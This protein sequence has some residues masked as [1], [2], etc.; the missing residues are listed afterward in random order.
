[1]RSRWDA[2]LAV[3]GFVV[4]LP[5]SALAQ[6]IT[7]PRLVHYEPA[8][9]PRDGGTI[10]GQVVLK[11]QID[12]NGK[13]S[14][15][16]VSRTLDPTLDAA[17][18]AAAERLQ[19]EPAQRGD[20]RVASTISFAYDFAAVAASAPRPAVVTAPESAS[21]SLPPAHVVTEPAAVSAPPTEVVVL[22][23]SKADRVRESAQAVD[24]LE[25]EKDQR[26]SADL[27]ELLGRTRGVTVQRAG[28]LGSYARFAL[29]GL[30]GDQI[31]F[32]L[33]GVPL[34]YAGFSFGLANVP[35]NLVKRVEVYRG[36]VPTRFGADALGGAV[37]LLTDERLANG[38]AFSYQVGAFETHRLT[39]QATAASR[40]G[41]FLST[42]AFYDTTQN[43]YLVDVEVPDRF[44]K[45]APARVRRFHDAYRAKGLALEAGLSNPGRT[46]LL[47]I[48][49]HYSDSEKEI[50][51]S[52]TMAVPYG[53][54]TQKTRAAGSYLRYRDHFRRDLFL[55]AVGG[56]N[57][58]RT[59]FRDVSRC[60]FNWFG[61]CVRD[62]I[63]PGEIEAGG[64]DVV[65]DTQAVF[66]R[67]TLEWRA[68]R[69]HRLRLSTTPEW[70]LRSVEERN[71]TTLSGIS[72]TEG[73]QRLVT[74]VNG[75]EYQADLFDER[76]QNVAFGKSYVQAAS[77]TRRL[78]MDRSE[79]LERSTLEW[80]MGDALRYR[81]LPELWAKVSYEYA[82]RLPRVE[83]VF[84]DGALTQANLE[85]RPEVSHNLNA[86]AAGRIEAPRT[87]SL[88]GEINLFY[89]DTEDLIRRT[90]AALYYSFQNVARARTFGVEASARIAN[91]GDRVSLDVAATIL[92]SRNRS[93][94]GP[95]AAQEGDRIPNRP[96]AFGSATLTV[97]W[98]ALVLSNDVLSTGWTT[99]YIH[100]FYRNWESLGARESKAMIPSQLVHTASVV[101]EL[102]S[103]GATVA[104]S[105]ELQ[106]VTDERSYDFFGVQR[107]GRAAFFKIMLQI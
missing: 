9:E 25:L 16:Q 39:A 12:R 61:E 72:A 37:D 56:Y 6:A 80:G 104:T 30:E 58:G 19:F 90:G 44:G 4:V 94:S 81:V 55:D 15:V 86:G 77:S 98:P 43:D 5:S 71:P 10:A 59:G 26:K 14:A 28:G 68:A 74:A 49:A 40:R 17:A 95:Y 88:R 106:N 93:T 41:L 102:T 34:D 101:Y 78:P 2:R 7:P 48:R 42:N 47:S 63:V 75:L 57:F 92:D 29:N 50:Q 73:T 96:F 79:N 3:A 23:T 82:T 18:V 33:D 89:R 65:T 107:P 11:L 38:A 60:V 76:L 85:L 84:G 22:G 35:V 103:P 67:G 83:E 8:V 51:N 20:Q 27:G 46:R 53:E 99:R 62:R 13:V 45:L 91:R 100:E 105:F 87:G 66:F 54:V 36:V 1:M 31:R 24:V 70:V 52:P 21:S 64:R 97:R 69:L 32:F